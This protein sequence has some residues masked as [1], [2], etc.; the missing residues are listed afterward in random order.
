MDTGIRYMFVNKKEN[1]L[2]EAYTL[3][4]K[5]PESLKA[6]TEVMGPYIKERGDQIY[7][8]KELARDP[9]SK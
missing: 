3:F 8:N 1:D 4:S 7:S 9:T 5:S 6:I 2:K